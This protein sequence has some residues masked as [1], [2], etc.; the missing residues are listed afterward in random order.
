MFCIFVLYFITTQST[1]QI[2]RHRLITQNVLKEFRRRRRPFISKLCSMF[3]N[4]LHF[5]V[6]IIFLDDTNISKIVIQQIVV[7]DLVH[8]FFENIYD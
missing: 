1:H 4:K 7:K 5:D 3:Q 6:R 2:K 8:T